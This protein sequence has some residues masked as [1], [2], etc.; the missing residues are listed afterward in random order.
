MVQSG[1][2]FIALLFAT[3]TGILQNPPEDLLSITDTSK[4]LTELKVDQSEESLISLISSKSSPTGDTSELDK[5]VK[6][7][8]E[9][10]F[11]ERKAAKKI[12]IA[13]GEEHKDYFLKMAADADPE[14][15]ETAKSILTKFDNKK[16]AAKQMGMTDDVLKIIAIRRLTEMKSTKALAAINALKSSKD[17]DI[18]LEAERASALLQGNKLKRPSRN[19]ATQQ[20]L[21]MIPKE[22]GFVAALDLTKPS[23]ESKLADYLAPMKKMPGMDMDMISGMFHKS[24]PMLIQKV[25][26]PQIDSIVFV[27][28]KEL[29]INNESSWVGFIG[30]GRYNSKKVKA[31]LNEQQME[32][33]KV[34]GLDY[35][36]ERWGPSICPVND[37]ILILSFGDNGS[38]HMAKML[39][40]AKG[41][42][43]PENAVNINTSTNRLVA[44]GKLSKNQKVMMK[45]EIARELE[46]MAGRNR[47]GVEAEKAMMKL[48]LLCTESNGFTGKLE[49]KVLVIQAEM[50]KEENARKMIAAIEK[51]D[52]E[53]RQALKEIPLPIFKAF[54]LDKRFTKSE[55]KAKT[56]TLRIKGEMLDML[57][58][59]PLMMFSK[60]AMRE[61]PAEIEVIMED[62]EE[63]EIEAPEVE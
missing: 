19:E 22:F 48:A 41:T 47:N 35:W 15:S 44:S 1:F 11:K 10:N 39:E 36:E 43:I 50:D 32:Q 49:D 51:A 52:L 56:V 4:V 8:R 29:G 40:N 61:P 63:V 28:S 7:L 59:M 55:V 46:R 9:G 53:I 34:N 62:I 3:L 17:K 14:V 42:E 45:A 23:K 31:L 2:S 20:V 33:K 21:K 27:S 37:E 57:T 16:Q 26:N 12:L 54:D 30:T 25:G 58:M 60:M 13:A 24:I 6:L 18:S 5:A 38:N